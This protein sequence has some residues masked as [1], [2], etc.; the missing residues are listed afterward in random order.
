MVSSEDDGNSNARFVVGVAIVVA[1]V[2]AAIGIRIQLLY[3][4]CKRRSKSHRFH[5]EEGQ[6]AGEQELEVLCLHEHPDELPE[7]KQAERELY[8][9]SLY[10]ASPE[11]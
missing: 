7:C 10:K 1:L 4:P 8:A 9:S 5:L 6:G 11:I 3:S 2:I